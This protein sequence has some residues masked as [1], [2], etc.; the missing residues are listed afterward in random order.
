MTNAP[1]KQFQEYI[2]RFLLCNL[3]ILHFWAKFTPSLAYV[4]QCHE[5]KGGPRLVGKSDQKQG[6]KRGDAFPGC[7][8]SVK[9]RRQRWRGLSPPPLF[10]HWSPE[11]ECKTAKCCW[12][13]LLRTIDKKYKKTINKQTAK[14]WALRTDPTGF[15]FCCQKTIETNWHSTERHSNYILHIAYCSNMQYAVILLKKAHRLYII[16]RLYYSIL[17]LGNFKIVSIILILS[18]SSS[19]S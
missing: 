19:F 13:V 16:P 11:N 2:C 10:C 7:C 4:Y 8:S 14:L 3:L 15:E 5:E 17:Y 1:L 18:P 9:G 6:L 12:C